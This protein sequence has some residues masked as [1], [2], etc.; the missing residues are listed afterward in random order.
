MLIGLIVLVA[1]IFF[2]VA[3]SAAA[4]PA[5]EV[6][7][8]CHSVP[9]LE[10]E[11]QGK[12]VSLTVD[13][14]RFSQS[15]HAPL[16]CAACHS[17]ISQVPH[18]AELKPVQCATCH[19][20]A[21]KVYSQSVH[22]KARTNGDGDAA[23][24]SDCHGKHDIMKAA[25]PQSKVYPLQ[26]PYT[27]GACHGNPELAKKH[28][29]P[30][31]NAYQ[32]YMDSIHGRALA[33]SGLLVAA[34]CASCHGSHDIKP[35]NDRDSKVYRARV[36]STCGSCHAGVLADYV[37]SVHGRAVNAGSSG[38]PVCIDCH[39]AHEIRRVEGPAWKLEIVK[40]CGTCHRQSLRTYRD[41]FHG[42]VTALGFTRVARCSDCHG[43]HQIRAISDRQSS[44]SGT[45]LVSTC[46][47]CHPKAN[48]N[49]VL[50]SPH[51]DP[52]DKEKYPR[53]YYATL[54]ME[55][56]LIGVFV[57]FGLHAVLWLL[58]SSLEVWRRRGSNG[59]SAKGPDSDD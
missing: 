48:E 24:C 57:F 32:L 19:S 28:N 2:P 31:A 39:T 47:K 56:L 52:T 46:R 9:G 15:V 20:D 14:Q 13:P 25:H 1:M 11:R 53:L 49:F 16:P 30:V 12:K 23:A 10:K 55:G 58:R 8:S 41:T 37:T 27:C 21:A 34:H 4:A 42:Q 50:Y 33:K 17:D 18:A 22:G 7:L 59:D 43:S 5:N 6:C 45:N 29:I 35:K 3:G 36:P 54:F 51:G 40:E 44:V 38:A 26:L